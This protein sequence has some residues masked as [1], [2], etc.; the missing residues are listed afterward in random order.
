MSN[1]DVLSDNVKLIRLVHRLE[2]QRDELLVV[3]ETMGLYAGTQPDAHTLARMA[4]A[5]IAKAK[6]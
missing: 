3:F 4:R 1:T 5:A 6:L 2:R